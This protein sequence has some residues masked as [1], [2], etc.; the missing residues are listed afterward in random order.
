MMMMRQTISALLIVVLP[1]IVTAQR[2]ADAP[3]VFIHATILDMTGA[4]AKR[5]MT[6]IVI[7]NK[8]EAI[9]RSGSVSVPKA[10]RIVNATGKYLMPGLWDMHV[11]LSLAGETGFSVLLANGV[12]GVR[13][14]GGDLKEIDAWRDRILTG[15]LAGPRVFRAGP[16]VDGPKDAE[17]RLTVNDPN[18]ARIAVRDLKRQGVDFIKVHNA[19]P[20]TAYF[21]L[22]AEAKKKNFSFV[23]HI[24][25]GVTAAE[26]SDAGQKSIEHTESLFDFPIAEAAKR[27]KDPKEIFAQALATF[28]GDMA[29]PL[30][31]K[32]V[33]N[34]T[35]FVPTLVEYRSFAFRSDI[36]AHPDERDKYVAASLKDYWKKTFPVRGN[37]DAYAAPKALLQEFIRLVGS[38][39]KE[40][41]DVMAG[42]DLGARDVYPGFSLHDELE[43]LVSAGFTPLDALR[44]ATV[45]P[46]RFF[47]IQSSSG[48]IAK[49]KVADLILLDA[50]PLENVT[51]LRKIAAVVANGR[52]FDRETLNKMLADVVATNAK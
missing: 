14:M 35:W 11:H 3:T 44:S 4:P 28:S 17:Y 45:G 40:G 43:L 49:G 22:A 18:E 46:A 41:V 32:F 26:V 20:P 24:P 7:G 19:I 31:R 10:S 6:V 50:D 23:G 9:G 39:K 47:G 13:D 1:F 34:R 30:F 48:T 29:K 51:N 42:T 12:T 33:K 16:V 27:S 21:A 37:A 52:Y 38:M 15:K 2:P 36:A 8:I 25:A 5:D